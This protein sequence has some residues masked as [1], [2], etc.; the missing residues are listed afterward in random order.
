MVLGFLAALRYFLIKIKIDFFTLVFV[1]Y[2]F[3]RFIHC[4]IIVA[5]N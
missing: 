1:C 3:Y 4:F 2:C 5:L